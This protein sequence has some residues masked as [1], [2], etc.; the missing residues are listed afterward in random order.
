[1]S[2]APALPSGATCCSW[3]RRSVCPQSWRSQIPCTPWLAMP[4]S[5]RARAWCPLWSL[6]SFP[7]ATLPDSAAG[8]GGGWEHDLEL[9]LMILIIYIYTSGYIELLRCSLL[10]R[11]WSSV[12][13]CWNMLELRRSWHLLLRPN[14]WEG[15]GCAVQGPG[16][17]PH[18]LGG[19][20]LEAQHGEEWPWW[21]ES[22]CWDHCRPDLPN[23]AAHGASRH[24]WNL[25]LVGR[26]SSEWRQRGRGNHQLEHH[27]Q[28]V[29][30]Q[31]AMAPLLLL[32]QSFAEDL[33]CHV[34]RQGWEQ[35]WCPKGLEG[36]SQGE[37]WC[38]LW[39][40]Q[41]RQLS[42]PWTW[43]C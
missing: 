12:G 27:E 24:A 35:V 7:M 33:Y 17:P 21:P 25:L 9:L 1:M 8:L 36:T 26:V 23:F 29:C 31:A 13:T 20:C 4:P 14:D 3:T 42:K 43:W 22:Q 28:P 11:T 18:L 34:V 2:R 19:C 16:R 5:L 41:G 39:Q 15:F 38:L 6:K 10:T 37:L 30:G 40:I 32:W